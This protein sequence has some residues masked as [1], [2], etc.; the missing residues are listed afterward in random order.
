[1]KQSQ[2]L[3]ECFTTPTCGKS[4][5]TEVESSSWYMYMHNSLHLT[6]FYS[7]IA[8]I[9]HRDGR[10]PWDFSPPI[11][12]FL[13][14]ALPLLTSYYFPI[15]RASVPPTYVENATLYETL[16]QYLGVLLTFWSRSFCRV[17][18]RGWEWGICNMRRVCPPHS[19]VHSMY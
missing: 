11:S 6:T 7:T 17:S 18:Y 8:L 12:S 3:R 10:V 16:V 1:M 15:L 5:A 19:C 4:V 13:P 2:N 9:F 14:Q